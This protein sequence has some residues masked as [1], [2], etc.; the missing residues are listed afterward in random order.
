MPQRLLTLLIACLQTF[1][2]IA[3]T[4]DGPFTQGGMIRGKADPGSQV[5]LDGKPLRVTDDGAFILGFGRDHKA[6]A[7]LVVKQANGG[8][9]T[10]QLK[11]K[12]RQ[13][14]IQRIDGLPSNK[15]SKF[16]DKA[17]KQIRDD[18]AAA[19]K[20]RA[21]DDARRDWDTEWQWPTTGPISGVYGS[22]R[23]LNGHP[24]RPH[25]GVDVAAPVGT[26]VRAPADGIVTLVRDMYFSGVTVIMDHGHHLT[27]SFLHLSKS[28]VRVGDEVRQGA[29]I[30]EVGATGR[31]TGPHLDWRMNLGSERIDPQL[32]VPPMPK[33]AKNQ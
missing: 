31:V 11:I 1:P 32:L 7:T 10:R 9:E 15:V 13:Y 17:L 33:Q 21:R 27:S 28:H 30:A 2:A 18:S 23:V 5:T 14:K 6:D 4:L 19:R 3:L 24:R 8:T 25:F 29:I 20:A 26:P 22:Q 12:P 16:S